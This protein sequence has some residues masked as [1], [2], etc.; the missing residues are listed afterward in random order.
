MSPVASRVLFRLLLI[1]G[2][3]V[4][5]GVLIWGI[6]GVGP[7]T[8]VPERA[9]QL[10]GP[11]EV[12]ASLEAAGLEVVWVAREGGLYRVRVRDAAGERTLHVDGLDGEVI[13][14]PGVAGPA[15]QVDALTAKLQAEGYRDIAPIEYERGAF[16]TTA[17]GPEGQR[18][19]LTLDTYTGEVLERAAP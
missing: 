15:M 14:M 1:F 8:V 7:Q 10:V 3:V 2:V 19:R 16:R 5:G 18:W 17:T 6:A 9:A 11:E 4:L 13:S 12:R